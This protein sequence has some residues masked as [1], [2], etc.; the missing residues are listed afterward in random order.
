MSYE[1]GIDA[2]SSIDLSRIYLPVFNAISYPV[3]DCV[4]PRT[5][6]YR[7]SIGINTAINI[8]EVV[9]GACINQEEVI[10]ITTQNSNGVIS[11]PSLLNDPVLSIIA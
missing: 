9:T 4:A 2:L 5:G 8:N 7:N 6:I 11:R 10:P 1:H 3:P